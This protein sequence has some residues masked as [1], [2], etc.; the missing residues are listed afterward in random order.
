[1]P[2][3]DHPRNPRLTTEGAHS[4]VKESSRLFAPLFRTWYVHIAVEIPC[5]NHARRRQNFGDANDA[6][7]EYPL[8]YVL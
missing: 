3:T 1:M 8:S 6:F 4:P 7:A 5:F 2:R